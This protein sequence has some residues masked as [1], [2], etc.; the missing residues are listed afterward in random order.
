LARFAHAGGNTAHAAGG[1]QPGLHNITQTVHGVRRVC[2]DAA[3]VLSMYG[4]DNPKSYPK[5][6]PFN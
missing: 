6:N 3:I 1:G 5:R 2:I 4:A